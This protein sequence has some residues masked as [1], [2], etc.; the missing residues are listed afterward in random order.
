MIN[1]DSL[2][3]LKAAYNEAIYIA[4]DREV[5]E[6]INKVSEEV[7]N[8]PEAFAGGKYLRL[9]TCNYQVLYKVEKILEDTGFTIT[10][11]KIRNTLESRD[12]YK[13]DVYLI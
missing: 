13:V 2:K 9:V 11:D 10:V 7:L 4:V 5:E 1:G 8:N 6:I 3:R 12:E